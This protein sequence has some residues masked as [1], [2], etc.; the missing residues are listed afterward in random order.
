[1]VNSWQRQLITS[2]DWYGGQDN[3]WAEVYGGKFTNDAGVSQSIMG[4][5]AYTVTVQGQ[6]LSDAAH[7]II[8]IDTALSHS[9][10]RF[11]NCQLHASTV[12]GSGSRGINTYRVELYQCA[13]I[14]SKT[15]GQI[16]NFDI[17]T[18]AGDITDETTAF[19]TGGASDGDTPYSIAMTP[20]ADGTRGQHY[21]LEGPWM[22]FKATKG[23]SKTVTVYIANSGAGDYDDDEVWLEV[24]YPSEIGTAAYSFETTKVELLSTPSVVADDTGSTWGTGGSNHQKLVATINPD[25]DGIAQ[26]RVIFGKAFASS[27]ETLY[28][29]PQPVYA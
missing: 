12:L 10:A 28:V 3:A 16:T 13:N 6:D 21:G 23:T 8:K 26:C 24:Y 29:D 25:Y 1:M 11:W 2:A 15:S 9:N 27:P 14:T 18:E 19:R 22:Y 5:Q 7:I 20:L 4:S 17:L